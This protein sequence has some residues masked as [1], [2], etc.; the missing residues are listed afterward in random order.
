LIPVL[1]CAVPMAWL[2]HSLA[3]RWPIES[4]VDLAVNALLALT[5]YT[6]AVSLVA[7]RKHERRLASD[8]I[9]RTWCDWR[10]GRAPEGRQHG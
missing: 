1:A 5:C 7:L 9:V 10:P 8:W 4:F 3:A 6:A 2:A